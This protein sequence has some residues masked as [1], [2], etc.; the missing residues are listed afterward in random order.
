METTGEVCVILTEKIKRWIRSAL[1]SSTLEVDVK[2]KLEKCLM[3]EP[4]PEVK[5][6]KTIPFSLVKCVHE[7]IQSEHG[8][9]FPQSSPL[10]V[11]Q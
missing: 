4:N 3:C 2:S 1:A 8:K 9:F 7:C 6:Q 10:D 5:K 11:L